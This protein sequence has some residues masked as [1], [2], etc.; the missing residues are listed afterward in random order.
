[1][2]RTPFLDKQSQTPLYVQL[3]EYFKREIE[4]QKILAGM[5]LPSIRQLS[6]HLKVSRNTVETAYHQLIAEGYVESKPKSGLHVLEI[7]LI[8]DPPKS[9][10]QKATENNSRQKS[11]TSI[12]FQYGDIEMEKFPMRE[13]RRCLVDAVDFTNTSFFTYGDKK[14][15]PGLRE[16]IA[17]YL[18]QARGVDCEAEDIVLCAG[19][20][21]SV[22]L[23]CQLLDL[24]NQKVAIENPGYGGV[25]YVFEKQ[26]CKVIPISLDSDGVVMDEVESS[27][28]KALYLTPSHQFPLGMVLSISKR[29][30]LLQWASREDCYLIEDD[31]D[32][33]FRYQ[34]QPIPSLKSLD[35]QDRVIY[36]GTFSKA[37]LPAT[38]VSYIVLPKELMDQYNKEFSFL[39]QS[40][41]PLI[42]EALYLFMKNG[43]FAKHI[44]KM[45][46]TYQDKHK[47][48]IES[49]HKYF[50][51]QVTIIGQRAGLHLLIQLQN[52]DISKLILKAS[53][54]G[55]TVYPTNT[56]WIN[57]ENMEEN[58]L[59]L[60][61]GGLT[62]EEI[63]EGIKRLNS[64]WFG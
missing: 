24:S 58:C 37:F 30:K 62:K 2:E 64:V 27:Q 4:E 14:G 13:W 38:R 46:K 51:D 59:M 49:L 15:H 1:M 56:F 63:E 45:R 55:V 43:H 21:Q 19:T 20:Q 34:G 17:N 42:Q 8:Y 12:D 25:R 54:A 33:E 18:F 40:V 9:P 32:S 22:Q 61:Y 26:K 57:S 16:E 53:K 10:Q 39:N 41:S 60:G 36:L 50:G 52:K 7:N 31:Y 35:H 5:K 47:K 3:Y 11:S 28:A 48:L 6:L 29:M 44:R 23:L